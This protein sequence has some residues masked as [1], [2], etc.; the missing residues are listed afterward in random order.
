M[1]RG[2]RR[3]RL[4]FLVLTHL[5][6][7]GLTFQVFAFDHWHQS[8]ADVRGVEGSAAHYHAAHCHG[9]VSGCADAGGVSAS[10]LN[11]HELYA[12]PASPF[13]ELGPQ[14]LDFG[15]PSVA[16]VLQPVPPPRAA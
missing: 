10:A 3:V 14:S 7:L 13:V 9:D 8:F 16:T 4:L 15:R 6:V 11:P 2:N 1:Y 5:V 12:V